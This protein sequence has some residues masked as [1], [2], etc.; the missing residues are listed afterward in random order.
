MEPTDD[1]AKRYAHGHR[2]WAELPPRQRRFYLWIVLAL[3]LVA[4]VARIAFQVVGLSASASSI[5]G[6]VLCLLILGPLGIAAW[7]ESKERM[8]AGLE[9]PATPVTGRALAGWIVSAIVLWVLYSFLVASQ[10][11]LIPV[12]PFLV[13]FLALRRHLQWRSDSSI[14]TL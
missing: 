3:V 1:S 12:L 2:T 8:L 6:L 9:P 11:F 4:P 13:S 10:G 7:R 14:F 5:I